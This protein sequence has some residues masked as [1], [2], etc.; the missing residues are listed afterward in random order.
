MRFQGVVYR[1]HDPRWSWSP[2]S[3]E[4]ARRYGGR[5][6]RI[7][8][9][10]LYTSLS[11]MTAVREASPLGR[12]LQP[13]LLCAYDADTEPIFNSLDGEECADAGVT[14][15]DLRCPTWRSVMYGGGVPPSQA[16][17]DRL[18]AAGYAG[19]QVRSFAPGAGRNDVNL[20]F[21]RWADR[22]PSRVVVID[23]QGRLPKA[24]DVNRG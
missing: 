8:V 9:P 14:D 3:G 19:M 7:G 20:V 5:F 4:G 23:D 10:A 15:S 12:P 13:I 2:A 22:L 16:V 17:A 1:A 6:N 18:I 11:P 24:E 21:W